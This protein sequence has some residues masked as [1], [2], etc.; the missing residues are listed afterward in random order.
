MCLVMSRCRLVIS[1]GC[2]IVSIC[3]V[4][5]LVLLLGRIGICVW[6]SIVLVFSLGIMKC[7]L[8][9]CLVLLVFS[10]WVWVCRFL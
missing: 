8:V 1:S 2:L 10:V 3:W 6:V 7:M 5:D 9:L 4:S